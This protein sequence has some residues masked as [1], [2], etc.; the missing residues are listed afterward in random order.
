MRIEERILM[1]S[2]HLSN[3]ATSRA[4]ASMKASH[5]GHDFSSVLQTA[6]VSF[7]SSA[8]ELLH[9]LARP[10]K[11]A[12][13]SMR[14]SELFPAI[15]QSNFDPP[16]PPHGHMHSSPSP[17]PPFSPPPLHNPRPRCQMWPCWPLTDSSSRPVWKL[18]RGL[19]CSTPKAEATLP[20][21]APF[22]SQRSTRTRCKK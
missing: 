8:R 11:P 14:D 1:Q 12:R 22:L 10:A 13:P 2:S 3:L 20:N 6:V 15:H 18:S 21:G 17:L 7:Q 5:W 9:T 19:S 4:S 16:P